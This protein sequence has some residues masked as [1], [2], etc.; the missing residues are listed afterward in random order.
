MNPRELRR[1]RN[2]RECTMMGKTGILLLMGLFLVSVGCGGG[3]APKPTKVPIPPSAPKPVAKVPAKEIPRPSGDVRVEPLPA[4][5]YTYNPQ[6]KPNP[7]QPLVVEKT[8]TAAGKKKIE[9]AV[10]KEKEEPGTPLEKVD[11][12]AL[13]LVAV[14]W[15]I[16]N[17][18]AMVEDSLGKGYILTLGTR[19][20][21]NQGQVTKITSAGVVVSEKLEA[22]DGKMRTVETPLRLY[23]D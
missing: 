21:K 1:R 14:V 16:T 12:K 17:P 6:G 23:T 5:S 10:K 3:E 13:K 7:F 19:V 4:T 15:D 9:Q 22:A 11:L 2:P 18:R 20:G 8:E